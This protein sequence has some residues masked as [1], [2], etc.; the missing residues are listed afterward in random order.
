MRRVHTR[1]SAN[2]TISITRLGKK[3][4]ILEFWSTFV[5]NWQTSVGL[6][7]EATID[8]LNKLKPFLNLQK[9]MA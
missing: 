7:I 1:L 4:K 6:S 5:L 8:T 3:I 2:D 9:L